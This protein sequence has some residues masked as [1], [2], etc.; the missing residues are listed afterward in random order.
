MRLN[1]DPSRCYACK[2]CQLICSFHHTGAFW[3]EKSSIEVFRNQQ[4]GYIKWSIDN[5]CDGCENEKEVLCVKHCVYYA[6]TTDVRNFVKDQEIS[7]G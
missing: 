3:P 5:T 2:R 6:L 1:Y 4:N 7:H